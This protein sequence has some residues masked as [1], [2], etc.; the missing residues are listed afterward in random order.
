LA[1]DWSKAAS[2]QLGP[3]REQLSDVAKAYANQAS[4][5]RSQY[6]YGSAGGTVVSGFFQGYADIQEAE[7]N[8]MTD[9]DE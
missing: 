2:F 5:L 6:G 9:E 3:R 4:S 8:V 7:Q 1:R